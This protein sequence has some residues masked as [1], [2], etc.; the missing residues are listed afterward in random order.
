M[1]DRLWYGGA[2]GKRAGD[3]I[4]A[5]SETRGNTGTV[6]VTT[7]RDYAR[8]FAAN[9]PLG[10]LY[11]VEPLDGFDLVRAK[12]HS[13]ETFEAPAV[14]VLSVYDRAV[15]M[16]DTERRRLRRKWA[17]AKVE[18]IELPEDTEDTQ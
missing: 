7:D 13:I 18:E 8:Q 16:T 2:S 15:Q 5:T 4:A 10:D 6:L 9:A 12:G 17:N 3:L 14:R 11:R 1:T